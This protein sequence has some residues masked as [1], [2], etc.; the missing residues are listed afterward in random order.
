MADKKDEGPEARTKKGGSPVLKKKRIEAM[1]TRQLFSELPADMYSI[2][3]GEML[4]LT[5]FR[6]LMRVA[7]HVPWIYQKFCERCPRVYL[8]G[9]QGDYKFIHEHQDLLERHLNA[10]HKTCRFVEY[11]H[12]LRLP[13]SNEL[14]SIQTFKQLKQ[15]SISY[16]SVQRERIDEAW[17]DLFR[18]LFPTTSKQFDTFI[19]EFLSRDFGA[20]PRGDLTSL[21][22][23]QMNHQ[24]Q[25]TQQA[26]KMLVL[27]WFIQFDSE[28]LLSM[29]EG[30]LQRIEILSIGFSWYESPS[31]LQNLAKI[32]TLRQLELISPYFQSSEPDQPRYRLTD[33]LINELG[34]GIAQYFAHQRGR[35][36]CLRTK[37]TNMFNL[38]ISEAK[39]GPQAPVLWT[40]EHTFQD[41][42]WERRHNRYGYTPITVQLEWLRLALL[43]SQAPVVFDR[44]LLTIEENLLTEPI[45]QIIQWCRASKVHNIETLIL[46]RD[47]SMRRGDQAILASPD[48]KEGVIINSLD[49]MRQLKTPIVTLD[50]LKR[51]CV[52]QL[53][54][55]ST[56]LVR[57]SAV[58]LHMNQKECFSLDWPWDHYDRV[59]NKIWPP[60]TLRINPYPSTTSYPVDP[61]TLS[62][63]FQL[64]N[65]VL[66]EHR[67]CQ[68][69]YFQTI[70]A[71]ENW[72]ILAQSKPTDALEIVNG[73]SAGR[74]LDP[75]NDILPILAASPRLKSLDT[76]G[77]VIEN[78]PE[79]FKM[80]VESKCPLESLTLNYEASGT[81]VDLFMLQKRS[82]KKLKLK[83]SNLH[84]G[85]IDWKNH[86]K[87][88][89]FLENQPELEKFLWQVEPQAFHQIKRLSVGLN[90]KKKHPSLRVLELS[91]WDSTVMI[92]DILGVLESCPKLQEL[93]LKAPRAGF[94]EFKKELKKRRVLSNE[95]L[96]RI[97]KVWPAHVSKVAFGFRHIYYP[98]TF[99]KFVQTREF[100]V[101]YPGGLSIWQTTNFD[102]LLSKFAAL[103]C[104]RPGCDVL[105]TKAVS[106]AAPHCLR[107]GKAVSSAVPGS[108]QPNNQL[109][110]K[111]EQLRRE[112]WLHPSPLVPQE[113]LFNT[114][115]T[116][117]F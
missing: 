117:L 110:E 52:D 105:K 106:S 17:L 90:T 26:L 107:P 84:A 75:A 112:T 71:D 48:Q 15:I 5:E 8:S 60:S 116:I 18:W 99:E 77:A 62:I 54:L 4:H 53:P 38:R 7:K 50:V 33:N 66:P 34:V 83:G 1:D 65:Q 9:V 115:R 30:S 27:P 78:L 89:T 12:T 61:A 13:S 87:L 41:W 74:P 31:I 43:N 14:K 28:G 24:V 96:E 70:T 102:H 63:W 104:L 114:A 108:F 2:I 25:T 69:I 94:F 40:F 73:F 67:R 45:E 97:A 36:L 95:Q 101:I 39:Q 111:N 85:S 98:S 91:V 11:S 56:L 23:Q 29:L 82:W 88:S 10:V 100:Q 21:V 3:F 51:L 92:E 68:H 58:L 32:N 46:E 20:D 57:H 44:V 16:R 55:M 37:D 47:I 81:F 93:Y 79:Y 109:L 72:S 19:L 64:N 35:S 113:N 103:H 80:L 86:D 22:V 42:W 76:G 49:Q 6:A 59:E